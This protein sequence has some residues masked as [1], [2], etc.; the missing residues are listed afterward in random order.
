MLTP[1]EPEEAPLCHVLAALTGCTRP[2][3]ALLRRG[4]KAS[5]DLR[6]GHLLTARGSRYAREI[7]ASRL[8]AQDPPGSQEHILTDHLRS[9]DCLSGFI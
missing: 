5:Q 2:L 4:D 3:A 8:S 6:S 9:L 7:S 1:Q